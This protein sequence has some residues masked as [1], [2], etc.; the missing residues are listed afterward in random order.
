MSQ[1]YI[2]EKSKNN[3]GKTDYYQLLIGLKTLMILQ[4]GEG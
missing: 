4:S 2:E 3:G 1:L